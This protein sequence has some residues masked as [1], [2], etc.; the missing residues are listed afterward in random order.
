MLFRG[1][2]SQTIGRLEMIIAAAQQGI[3]HEEANS[4][5][6]NES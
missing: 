1:W 5:K 3:S 4:K 6:G 2:A